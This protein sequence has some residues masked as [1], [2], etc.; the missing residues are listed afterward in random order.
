[1]AND[2]YAESKALS[3]MK[4]LTI[5]LLLVIFSPLLLSQHVEKNNNNDNDS[6]Q[7]TKLVV[8]SAPKLTVEFSCHYDFGIYELSANNNGDFS[9]TQ[10]TNGENFGVRHGFG[11][12]G[13]AKI[14]IHE[15]GYLRLCFMGSYNR[16][17]SKFSKYLQDQTE[18]GF[19]SYNV[20]SFAAG[21]ENNF[22]PGYRFKP[23]VG[24]GVVGSVISGSA[25]VYDKS[26]SNYR[27]LDIIPAFRLGL[28]FYSGFE[29][30]LNNKFGLN[31]G[32]RIVHANLW[33]KDTKISEN[34][35]EIFLN[36]K[37][38]IPRIPYSGFRQFMWG[39]LY[40]GVNY[41]FG[42]TQKDYYYRK[43]QSARQSSK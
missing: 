21:I 12:T 1:M 40:A 4:K 35:N 7:Y 11:V 24:I 18:A 30:L 34:P 6:A 43:I 17:S 25:R 15:Q 41:Y 23:L 38:V 28:T 29:Y 27:N 39:S 13:M 42:I 5:F 20:F 31:C 3:K 32:I 26:P 33:L 9:S 14:S 16:F 37:R 10:F 19:A 36:D 8:R 22:T 2:W